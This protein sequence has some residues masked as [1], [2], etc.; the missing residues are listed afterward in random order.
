MTRT[1]K[2]MALDLGVDAVGV[3]S[4]QRF[5][6]MAEQLRPVFDDELVLDATDTGQRWIDASAK[7]AERRRR[8][9]VPEDHLAGAASVLVLGLRI[10]KESVARTVR[11]PAEAIGPY[12]FATYQSRRQLRLIGLTLIKALQG[13][14]VRCAATYDLC[15]TGSL[16]ANPRGPQPNAFANRFAAVAAGLGTITRGGF[17]NHPE[18][19]ANMRYLALVLDAELTEDPL[20]DLTAL[21]S[22]CDAG[23]TNCVSSCT[24]DA[25]RESV[26]LE[27]DGTTLS[28]NP[29]EQKRCDWALRYGLIPEEGV[30]FTGSKSNAP[31]PET[32]TA[33]ALAEGMTKRDTILKIRPCV[34]EMCM[35]A[36]PYTRP[37]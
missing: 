34:A 8:F 26:D 35:M 5:E 20:A 14:G 31:I 28:F 16:A 25:F 2:S 17:V 12:A 7:V 3:A 11:E 21:R 4:A 19:G 9:C 37:Q 22:R 30:K 27:L 6:T 1:L 29:V 13:W 24:V 18:H 15:N 10:P 23:C 33:E 36:C 32:I